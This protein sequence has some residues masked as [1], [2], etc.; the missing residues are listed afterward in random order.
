MLFLWPLLYAWVERFSDSQNSALLEG[1]IFR[2]I[3]IDP[4]VLVDDA[5]GYSTWDFVGYT[6]DTPQIDFAERL[7]NASTSLLEA[8][9]KEMRDRFWPLM[10]RASE[11]T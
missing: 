1:A 3:D 10:E 7:L 4:T 5:F 2:L 6:I 11:T 8:L 9:P